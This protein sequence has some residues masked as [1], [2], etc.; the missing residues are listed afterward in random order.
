[1]TADGKGMLSVNGWLRVIEETPP[2]Y[3]CPINDAPLMGPCQN[4][5]CLLWSYA[6]RLYSCAGAFASAKA[7]NA[8]E[9]LH[10]T[11]SN[12]DKQGTL[13]QAAAG[14]LSFFDLAHFFS[15][16]RQRVEGYVATGKSLS[17]VMEPLFHATQ[18]DEKPTRRVGS[19]M[20]FTS[21]SPQPSDGHR[22]CVCCEQR[23]APDDTG[24][25]LALLDRTEVAW[26]SHDCVQEFPLDAYLIAV[27]YKRHW[28]DVALAKEPIDERSRVREVTPERMEALRRLALEQGYH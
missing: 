27:R 12:K 4:R 21:V 19:S 20:R 13:R 9:R 10:S 15:L 22:V 25:V 16:S 14:K 5:G 7:A 24:T 23:I 18:A 8:E 17:E 26:C 11:S 6:P 1:M 28:T 2:K 3:H